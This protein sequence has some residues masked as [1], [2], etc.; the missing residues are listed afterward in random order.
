M[1]TDVEPSFLPNRP[2][3]SSST[4]LCIQRAAQ[5]PFNA[6][7]RLSL[8]KVDVYSLGRRFGAGWGRIKGNVNR[9]RSLL[10]VFISTGVLV[11][12]L[13]LPASAR[14]A[15][16]DPVFPAQWSL[17]QI[18]APEAWGV[19]R[20]AGAT[21][22]VV[23]SGI[24]LEH[25]DLAANL[26]RGVSTCGAEGDTICGN[27]DWEQEGASAC[28]H[29]THVAGIAAA[30]AN[31]GTGI[32]GV[33]PEAR[34]MPVKITSTTATDSCKPG[35]AGPAIK[36]ATDHRAKV[37]NLSV[38]AIVAA[39]MIDDATLG[40]GW[41]PAVKYATSRDV[42]VVASAGN[43]GSPLCDTPASLPGVICV[44]ATDRRELHA[45]YSNFG[46]KE[47]NTA[48]SAPGGSTLSA[49]RSLSETACE[50]GVVSTV[51][52][53][54]AYRW[55]LACGYPED[56]GYAEKAGTSM[57]APHVAGV[58]ALLRSLHCNAAQTTD[59]ITKQARNPLTGS[60]GE[61]SVDYGYGI[62][63]AE[64]SVKEASTVCKPPP[65]KKPRKKRR[66]RD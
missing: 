4:G 50:E 20:G 63:D 40:R 38:G 52:L 24:D 32:V 14:D 33:A 29:G 28:D 13:V 64:A 18:H 6:A 53:G 8:D 26:V 46:I 56:A 58:A 42:V 12:A 3:R 34:I 51:P 31:N 60:R 2:P 35:A 22:A 10:G 55:D 49:T 54:N 25:P 43:D 59:I 5:E 39:Q 37:I 66:R 41:R 21:I 62:V 19:T 17:Q 44:I 30:V 7:N 36:W 61:W 57:A 27:G 48:V 23:D 15:I 1:A 65:K 9:A 11:G 47:P 16:N 45:D